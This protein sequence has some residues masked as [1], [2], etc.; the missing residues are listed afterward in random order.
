LNKKIVYSFT[1]FTTTDY[2]DEISCIVWHI[3]CNLLCSY[4]YN[5]NIV[6]SKQGYYSHNDI[7]DF[8]KSRVGLL[9]AVVLS[10]GCGKQIL[11]LRV[12]VEDIQ[13]VP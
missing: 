4:C 3:S 9:S 10:G 13:L 12:Q 2:Q 8:L 11:G 5:D 6:F 1:K 7:L